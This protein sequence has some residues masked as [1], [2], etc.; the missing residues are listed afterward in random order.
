M[1]LVSIDVVPDI[2][3]YNDGNDIDSP[4]TEQVRREV[5]YLA[6]LQREVIVKHYLEGKIA[7]FRKYVFYSFPMA[8]IKK[9][10]S[11]GD[12]VPDSQQKVFPLLP[13]HAFSPFFI[14][15]DRFDQFFCISISGMI[16]NLLR[17]P[18]FY[19]I[20]AFHNKNPAAKPLYK[21]QIMGNKKNRRSLFPVQPF[22]KLYNLRLNRNV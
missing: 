11:D 6:K 17:F 1:P 8:I 22:Q 19:H 2:E 9:A 16:K 20:S 12:F 13:A 10:I 4:T 3:D 5:A 14:C 15:R 7:E 21:T 18:A